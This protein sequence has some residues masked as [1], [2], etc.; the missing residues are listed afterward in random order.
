MKLHTH[1]TLDNPFPNTVWIRHKPDYFSMGNESTYDSDKEA[2]D[3][4]TSDNSVDRFSKYQHIAVCNG[5]QSVDGIHTAKLEVVYRINGYFKKDG[6]WVSDGKKTAEERFPNHKSE[7]DK[8]QNLLD[9]VVVHK[10]VEEI[11]FEWKSPR[12]WITSRQPKLLNRVNKKKTR[13]FSNISDVSL[14][15]SNEIFELLNNHSWR[16]GLSQFNGVYQFRDR[17]TNDCY[18]GSAYGDDGIYCRLLNYKNTGHGNNKL[19]MEKHELNPKFLESYDFTI[20]E[21]FTDKTPKNVVISAEQKW[22][23]IQGSNLNLN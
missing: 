1:Q 22:K 11:V 5:S 23:K 2:F 15:P 7:M 18:V 4:E 12:N 16:L 20:L 14:I 19:L 17:K 3:F 6:Q 21:Y 9:L 8:S 10:A 13:R